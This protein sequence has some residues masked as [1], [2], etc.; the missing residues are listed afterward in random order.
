MALVDRDGQ[1]V[2]LCRVVPP[3]H[4]AQPGRVELSPQGFLDAL[5]QGAAELEAQAPEAAAKIRAVTFAT[6]TNSFIL[7]DAACRPLTPLILWPDARAV[8]LEEEL[9]RLDSLPA[10]TET[11]GVAALNRDFMAAKLLW[12]QRESPEIWK[13]AA[14]ICLI[15]DYLTLLLTG[16]HVTEAGA[17]RP[18]GVA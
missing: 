8:D 3:V 15:S 13:S 5:A 1:L 2:S 10:F 9:H 6:Q 11:T 16:Q 4:A 17:G 18:H 14:K 12:L 7:L